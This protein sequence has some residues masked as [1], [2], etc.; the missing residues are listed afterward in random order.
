MIRI[1]LRQLEVFVAVCN[2]GSTTAAAPVVSLSQSATSAAIN[3]L[4]SLLNTRLFDRVGKRL[5]LNGFGETL[6]PQARQLLSTAS[7]IEQQFNTANPAIKLGL[8]ISSSTTIGTYYLPRLLS[9]FSTTNS[10]PTPS[11]HIANTAE[12]IAKVSG[13]DADFGLIEGHCTNPDLFVEPWFKDELVV[14]CAPTYPLNQLGRKLTFKEL[15]AA[16]WLLREGGSGTRESVESALIPHLNTLVC[17]GEFSN[18]EAIKQAALVGL[19]LACLSRAV[20]ADF[21]ALG[22]L[23]ELQT[24]LPPL[25]RNFYI[26]TRPER[27]MLPHARHFLDFCRNMDH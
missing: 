1:S 14:V 20:V 4:E 22:K 18:S 11:V 21:L 13:F 5:V 10:L 27:T 9:R 23:V 17:A 26:Q 2:A 16:R 12:V 25:F 8:R 6:L 19:G 15:R 7:Q 24:T 3:E